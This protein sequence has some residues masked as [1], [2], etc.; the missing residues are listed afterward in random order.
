MELK[1]KW[2]A[3]K[4]RTYHRCQVSHRYQNG[5]VLA[6]TLLLL[7]VLS[8]LAVMAT[9]SS[10][11]AYKMSVNR[12]FYEEA[13]NNS[14]STRNISRTAIND[15]LRERQWSSV[16]LTPG[17][18]VDASHASAT[19]SNTGA[20]PIEDRYQPDT[21]VRDLTYR[22]ARISGDVYVLD[23]ITVPNTIGAG[24]SQHQGYSGIG[25]G[26][27]SAGSLMKL[28]EVRSAGMPAGR[29]NEGVKVWTVS[30]YRFIL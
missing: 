29:E 1:G 7:L 22:T 13:F 23:G 5:A 10:L 19:Q 20:S 24:S 2:L 14:E 16:A 17:L 25:I 3:G 26:L 21:L 28:Y 4:Y 8:M 27:G 12:V 9:E 30:D 15:Y 18:S 6:I 11:F